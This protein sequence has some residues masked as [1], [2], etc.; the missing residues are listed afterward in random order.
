M[1]LY[2]ALKIGVTLY[3]NIYFKYSDNNILLVNKKL[4]NTC[5]KMASRQMECNFRAQS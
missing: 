5:P 2:V 4:S 3:L 1:H